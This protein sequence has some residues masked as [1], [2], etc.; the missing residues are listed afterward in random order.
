[1]IGI[2]LLPGACRQSEEESATGDQLNQN[3]RPRADLL[4]FPDEL[5]AEDESVNEFVAR[6]MTTCASGDYN[7]FRLLWSVLGEPLPRDEYDKGWQAVTEIRIRALKEV[8]LSAGA[9]ENSGESK[10]AYVVLADVALAP[11]HP[12]ARSE[13]QRQVVLMIVEERD[14]WRLAR[15][16]KRVR[17]WVT[18]R[19]E[20]QLEPPTEPS[21]DVGGHRNGE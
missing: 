4:V 14:E 19:A 9:Q 13:P 15:A 7:A 12:A 2:T 21:D 16:P 8:S 20:A 18:E 6:A 5:R 17:A 3:A 11:S 10:T 1:M